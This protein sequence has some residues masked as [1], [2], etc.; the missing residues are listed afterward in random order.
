MGVYIQD[1]SLKTKFIS[2]LIYSVAFVTILSFNTVYMVNIG[3]IPFILLLMVIFIFLM[4]LK[5]TKIISDKEIFLLLVYF[6]I[7]TIFVITTNFSAFSI[8]NFM[9]AFP[10]CLLIVN[11]LANTNQLQVFLEILSNIIFLIACISLFFWFLSSGLRVVSPTSSY[12]ISWGETREIHSFYNIYF[13]SQGLSSDGLFGN[14]SVFSSINRNCAIFV[15]AVFSNFLFSLGFILNEFLTKKNK[16]RIIFLIAILSTFTTS[17]IIAFCMFSLYLTINMKPHNDLLFFLKILIYL[18]AFILAFYVI[19]TLLQHKVT[20]ISGTIRNY[21]ISSEI[22][23]FINS[24]I[25]GNGIN[26]FTQGSSNALSAVLADGGIL[27][28]ALYYLPI[29]IYFINYIYRLDSK[30]WLIIVIIFLLSTTVMQYT[31]LM[32]ML[33]CISWIN[34]VNKKAIL[35]K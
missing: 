25:L 28:M 6:F 11:Y 24:P 1:G 12:L 20:T 19:V 22:D 21:K 10:L 26:R 13:E 18:V 32:Y 17:G 7:A 16:K 29:F 27:L 2:V 14:L 15:E 30:V 31:N 3:P 23:A 35:Y 4:I 34:L 8:F 33:I 5:P 9:L